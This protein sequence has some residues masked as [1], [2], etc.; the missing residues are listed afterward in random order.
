MA[1]AVCSRRTLTMVS[2]LFRSHIRSKHCRVHCKGLFWNDCRL[3][4]ISYTDS[5][6]KL[7]DDRFIQKWLW[8]VRRWRFVNVD[9]LMLDLEC[10]L[11]R[12]KQTYLGHRPISAFDPQR[13][14]QR[15]QFVTLLLA[16]LA[17]DI[18]QTARARK[19][20]G[21]HLWILRAR[22]EA[23][24]VHRRTRRSGCVTTGRA[25]R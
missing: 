6:I 13:K 18:N 4:E 7:L 20:L 23:P 5:D 3:W 25:S 15:S 8:N 19:L 17:D 2:N 11:L 1:I 9:R 21:L 24:R 12:V 22:N 14:S 16:Y 10:V